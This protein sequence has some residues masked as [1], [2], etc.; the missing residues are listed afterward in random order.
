MKAIIFDGN[1]KVVDDYPIPTPPAGEVLIRTLLSAI[2]NTDLEIIKGYA[3]F[4]GILGHEFVGERPDGCLLYTSP[5]P[6]DS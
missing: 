1:L 3:N 5:S 6:R 4:H 2:C